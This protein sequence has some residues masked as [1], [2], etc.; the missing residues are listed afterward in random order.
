M[1]K[2]S[3]ARHHAKHGETER[4]KS[5]TKHSFVP[6]AA[7][8]VQDHACNLN[9]AV[10]PCEAR[11]QRCHRLRHARGIDDQNHGQTQKSGKIGSRTHTVR[12]RA[13]E[14][15]H[16]AFDD[17]CAITRCQSRDATR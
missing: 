9:R 14:K 8:A 2:T 4:S 3:L 12:G 15:A 6:W 7:D 11:N 16:R 5:C 10:V 13:I 1:G 17:Q